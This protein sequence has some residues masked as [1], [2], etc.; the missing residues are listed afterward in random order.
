MT[1]FPSLVMVT[2]AVLSCNDVAGVCTMEARPAIDLEIRDSVTSTPI[3]ESAFATVL[4]GAFGDS[5]RLCRQTSGGVWISRCGPDERAGT[6]DVLV[7]HASHQ[8]WSVHGVR[9]TRDACHVRTVR[10]QVRMQLP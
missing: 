8:F 9:V 10:L 6:Y 2:W 5:L 4:D 1:R 3:A 7:L